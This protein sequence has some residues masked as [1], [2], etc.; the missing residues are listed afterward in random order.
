MWKSRFRR[1]LDGDLGPV[2]QQN[3]KKDIDRISKQLAEGEI[4]IDE[5]GVARNCIGRVVMEDILEILAFVTDKVDEKA[6][7]AA[8]DEE[9]HREIE[10]YRKAMANYQPSAEE[11][12]EMKAAFGEDA[13]VVDI[14]TGKQI[15]L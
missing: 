15:Q 8:S 4:T 1:E 6:T 7:R 11:L 3:A 13:T 2:W 10:E 12:L 9:T 14:I 5:N